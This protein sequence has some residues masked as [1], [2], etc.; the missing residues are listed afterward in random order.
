[1]IDQG[2][3]LQ[4]VRMPIVA[5]AAFALGALA[6]AAVPQ[7]HPPTSTPAPIVITQTPAQVQQLATRVETSSTTACG[8]GAYVTGDLAGDAS[9]ASV[10]A[11]MCGK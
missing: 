6:S 2:T 11:S 4:R 1:M 3:T 9:P 5:L 10:Y 7:L 8:Q